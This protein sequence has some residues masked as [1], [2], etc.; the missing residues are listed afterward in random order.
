MLRTGDI[1]TNLDSP[2]LSVC[3]LSNRMHLDAGTGRVMV[4]PIIPGRP[5]LD[6]LVGIVPC[7]GDRALLPEM[8]HW[9]PQSAIE[10]TGERVGAGEVAEAVR[11]V[12]SLIR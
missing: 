6:E 12:Y 10:A 11:L 2:A 7:S 4:C 5:P 9:L 1:C 3:V 8:T